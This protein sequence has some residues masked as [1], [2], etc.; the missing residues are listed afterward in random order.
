MP[1]AALSMSMFMFH[2][3]F[4]MLMIT[5]SSGKLSLTV[6]SPRGTGKTCFILFMRKT[7]VQSFLENGFRGR[8]ESGNWKRRLFLGG[9]WVSVEIEYEKI[10][11]EGLARNFFGN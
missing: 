4:P 2:P 3:L 5:Y 9:L 6:T 10:F 7:A 8:R 1:M 11:F